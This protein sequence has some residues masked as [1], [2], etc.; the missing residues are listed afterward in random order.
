MQALRKALAFLKNS[1]SIPWN[2]LYIATTTA[3]QAYAG[4]LVG[5]ADNDYMMRVSGNPQDW[6]AIGDVD[7][8]PENSSAGDNLT[9][10]TKRF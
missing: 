8:L 1:N 10:I 6:I 7:D 5:I 3:G 2:D 4:V 9:L